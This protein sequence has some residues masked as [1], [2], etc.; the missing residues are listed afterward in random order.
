[1]KIN[2]HEIALNEAFLDD[3]LQN[4]TSK[5]ELVSKDFE[6]YKALPEG[7][8]KALEYLTKAARILNDVTLEQDHH[9]NHA[10]K[11][12]LSEAAKTSEY[13]KKTLAFFNSLNGV[14]GSNGIDKEHI[15]I[16]KG[17]K[18]YA[19]RN[20]YPHDMSVEEFHKIL[21]EMFAQNKIET[22]K[23]ILS[24]R[25][26]VRR[27]DKE[28]EAIDYVAYFS[29]EFS[30]AA[31]ELDKAAKVV[32]NKD[33]AEYLV[34][35][36]KALRVADEPLDAKADAK[37]ATLQDTDLEFTLGR[38]NYDDEMTTTIFENE[39]IKKLLEKHHIEATSKDML[40][41]RVGIINKKGTELILEFKDHMSELVG[42]MPFADKY[43][44]NVCGGEGLKQTMVDVDLV[45]LTGDYA[46][47]R[48]GITTAQNLP[49]N[50]KL[51]IKQGNGRR[52]A[53][54]R[55][56][57]MSK[58]TEKTA[59]IL[60]KLVAKELHPFYDQGDLSDHLFVIG[61]ENG[62]SFGPNSAY[63]NA[64]GKYKHIIEEHK[65][66]VISIAFM[67]EYV[68]AGVIDAKALKEIYTSWVVGRL[69]MRAEA[70]FDHPHRVADLMQFN[71]LLEHGVTS[72]DEEGKLHINFEIFDRVMKQFLAETIEVQLSKSPKV[73]ADFIEKN[74]KWGKDSARIAKFLQELGLKP[75]K[76]IRTYI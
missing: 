25:T 39:T 12:A 26:M 59:K 33:F 54:H 20:F 49:N 48:G 17:I 19:G 6:G 67:P 45:A 7:D 46:Q 72:F 35:Q 62:H 57:R 24:A 14:E 76:D 18:G 22:L 68:K 9:L 60:E 2:G 32:T 69:F 27:K 34:L 41:V 40:G 61:H 42:L 29:K 36:A 51:S 38:E 64:L 75:Y 21:L 55:Q 58:D 70:K 56:V 1:M 74:G 53:Y 15:E 73:A 47:C 43:E 37:W 16:F 28:L 66:D 23:K 44:Q 8:K 31:D 11:N 71:Y 50:D 13:A 52:N 4:K 10:Q 3:A 65:A 5:I 30:A 63:Q